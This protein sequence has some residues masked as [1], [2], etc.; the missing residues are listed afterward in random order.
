MTVLKNAADIFAQAINNAVDKIDE[1]QESLRSQLEW[2][3]HAYYEEKNKN[4]E[5]KKELLKLIESYT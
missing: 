1:E 5:F 3:E 2:L 4:I